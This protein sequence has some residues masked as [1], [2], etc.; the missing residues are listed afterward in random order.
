MLFFIYY[1]ATYPVHSAAPC[2]QI[3]EKTSQQ[4]PLRL[5]ERQHHSDFSVMAF[6]GDLS[7][8][9]IEMYLNSSPRFY[10]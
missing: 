1:S 3:I 4:P 9:D 7:Y 2:L 5:D 10:L 8:I 6:R